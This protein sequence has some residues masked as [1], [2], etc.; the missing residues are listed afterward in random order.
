MAF[1]VTFKRNGDPLNLTD[2]TFS[3]QIR[4][5]P[6]GE[7]LATWQPTVTDPSTGQVTFSLER[8]ETLG[9]PATPPDC[10]WGTDGWAI[11]SEGLPHAIARR[12]VIVSATYTRA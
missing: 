1:S 6:T 12:D 9:I 2:W 10:V 3:S 11:D 7:I 5:V 8:N 4:K